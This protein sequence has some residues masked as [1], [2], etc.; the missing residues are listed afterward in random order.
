MK[1]VVSAMLVILASAF[2][3]DPQ[4]SS[5]ITVKMERKVMN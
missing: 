3:F 5:G 4:P 2:L 1:G